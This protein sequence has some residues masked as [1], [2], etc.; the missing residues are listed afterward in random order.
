MP[1]ARADSRTIRPARAIGRIASLFS[2][3]NRSPVGLVAA[4]F[5]VRDA[6]AVLP[7]NSGRHHAA[8]L[9]WANSDAA[10]ADTNRNVRVA[11]FPVVTVV[12]IVA[13]AV[14]S[15]LDID[16]LGHLD[17]FGF[18]RSDERGGGKHRYGCRRGQRD[19]DH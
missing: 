16:G 5:P 2:S 14:P 1:T 19:L 6:A 10:R 13:V 18:D 11:T 4:A 9:S 7:F 12:S 8:V 3:G 15:D 17:A